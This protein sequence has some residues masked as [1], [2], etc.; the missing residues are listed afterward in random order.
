[1]ARPRPARRLSKSEENTSLEQSAANRYY[2]AMKSQNRGKRPTDPPAQ[3]RLRRHEVAVG[4]LVLFLVVLVAF[5][6]VLLA[7]GDATLM[8]SDVYV[9]FLRV[10]QFG[11]DQLRHGNLALWSDNLFSGIPFLGQFHA[12]MLYPPNLIFLVLPL[13]QAITWSFISHIWLIGFFM[14]LW[15][16]KRGLDLP[17]ALLPGI[18]LMLGGTVFLHVWEGHL[19]DVC[20]AAWTPLLLLC[21]DGL[22]DRAGEWFKWSLV[23]VAALAMS[24]LAGHPQYVF[25]SSLAMGLYFLLRLPRTPRPAGAVVALAAIFAGGVALAAVQLWTGM[26]ASAESIRGAGVSYRLATT[27][28]F[29]FENFLTLLAPNFFGN[30][31][32]QNDPSLMP[33]W[34]QSYQSVMCLFLGVGGLA[35]AVYGAWRGQRSQRRFSAPL[36]GLL[37][38]LALGASTPL[39]WWLYHYVPGFDKFR[40]SSKFIFQASLF[41]LMLSGVGLDTMRR[42]GRPR[43]GFVLGVAIGAAVIAAAA[44]FIR[45]GWGGQGGW[46]NNLMLS[47]HSTDRSHNRSPDLVSPASVARAAEYASQQ[48]LISAGVAALLAALLAAALRWPKAIFAVMGL[49]AAEVLVFASGY[50]N[51]QSISANVVP[52]HVVS[53]LAR[54][55]GDYRILIDISPLANSAMYFGGRD[56]W[57]HDPGA[58]GRYCQLIAAT[59]EHDPNDCAEF[60]PIT[61]PHKIFEMLRLRYV[62]MGNG[63]VRVQPQ[64]INRVNLVG[65]YQLAPDRQAMFKTLLSDTFDPRQTVLLESKPAI[66]PA[67]AADLGWAKVV[68]SSTDWLTIEAQANSPCLL[69]VTDTYSKYWRVRP[70]AASSQQQ[71]DVL[72]ANYVLRAVPLAAGHHLLRMEYAPSGF[73]IGKWFSLGSLLLYGGAVALYARR[74]RR[75][76][77]AQATPVH[78]RE[79]I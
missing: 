63:Q 34:G 54:E 64:I 40:G 76:S 5:G 28:S 29:R 37:L 12:A 1:V 77:L 19:I 7:E 8:G 44:L 60:F 58:S 52:E 31:T 41:I 22:C 30:C 75:K 23:G 56:I 32:S 27:H 43:R 4:A 33:Y 48:L 78:A 66:E 18:L 55:P 57:G 36:A 26:Q 53:Q 10:R 65:R 59:Q 69:L 11:F 79:A 21:V 72:P 16:R 68:A 67:A 17:S 50:K 61:R 51:I 46:W 45:F 42:E 47:I 35:L 62:L 13:A 9:Q 6:D 14:F 49:A 39:F 25:Y 24:V 3:S 71:Y 74:L 70:M 38:L 20:T 73:T 15:C 2:R